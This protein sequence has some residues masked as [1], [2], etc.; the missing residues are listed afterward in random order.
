MLTQTQ[1]QHRHVQ[2]LVEMER[3]ESRAR[4]SQKGTTLFTS[5]ALGPLPWLQHQI[6]SVCGCGEDTHCGG[7]LEVNCMFKWLKT[8]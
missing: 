2:H 7:M 1:Q 6:L 3:D 4:Y 5:A 8:S